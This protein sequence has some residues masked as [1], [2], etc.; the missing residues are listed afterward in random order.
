MKCERD[1]CPEG[2]LPIPSIDLA[3]KGSLSTRSP[4]RKYE[5]LGN[6]MAHH[7][8]HQRTWTEITYNSPAIKNDYD[9]MVE[10]KQVCNDA[11]EY[12]SFL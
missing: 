11:R 9:V 10:R 3:H 6:E 8:S 12:F 7:V 2:T 1:N 5:V 4:L